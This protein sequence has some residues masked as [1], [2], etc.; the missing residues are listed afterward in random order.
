[1]NRQQLI[2][3]LGSRIGTG[4]KVLVNGT[5]R[6]LWG[7][8]PGGITCEPGGPFYGWENNTIIPYLRPMST[9]TDDE[10][11]AIDLA[12]PSEGALVSWFVSNHIDYNGLIDAGCALVAPEDMYTE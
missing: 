10:W 4:T 8:E 7:V 12:E 11:E 1:M 3:D 9:M 5:V 6:T 2:F